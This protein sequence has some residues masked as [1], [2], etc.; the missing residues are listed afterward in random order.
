MG[1]RYGL[2]HFIGSGKRKF[3]EEEKGKVSTTCR[4]VAQDKEQQYIK[5]K[6]KI[7][8]QTELGAPK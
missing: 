2:K 4:V 5:A 6:M 7:W 8:H 3:N 1:Q